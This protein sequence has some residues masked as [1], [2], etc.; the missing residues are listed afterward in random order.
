MDDDPLLG[1][2][3]HP[4][5]LTDQAMFNAYFQLLNDPL[6]DYTFSQLFTWGNSLRILWKE[7]HGH[8]C[9]FANGTGDL[10]LLMPP[11][12]QA[13]PARALADAFQVMDAYNDAH[14]AHGHSRVEYVSEELLARLDR[15]RLLVQPM[16]A[17]YVYDVARMIDLAGGDLA[18][19]RQLRNRFLRNY[20]FR[21]EPYDASRHR[22][23]CIRLLRLWKCQADAQHAAENTTSSL[24]RQKETLACQLTLEHAHTLGIKGLVVYTQPVT[25]GDPT[26]LNTQHPDAS[27]DPWS[28]SAFT[29]GEPL[30]ADQS[31]ILIEKTDL[32]VR[33]LAQF[34]FSE[35]CRLCWADRPLVN[36]GDDWG[37]ETLA[38]T[39]MS[40]RPVKLLR[41]YTLQPASRSAVQVPAS[42]RLARTAFQVGKPDGALPAPVLIGAP[43]SVTH[44]PLASRG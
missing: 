10:T 41:K 19:K 7:L 44:R 9:V 29:F 35:F 31:S 5:Q 6:S 25:P 16:G 27:P 1:L 37:L 12:G 23:A 39:K 24:K 36:A 11:I 34:V 43:G 15:S 2:G 28:L 13:D 17:D 14:H 32:N 18:A 21:V 38:W 26:P 33:G 22:D 20:R 8:L 40:Y 4:V 42:A 3:L 30:G